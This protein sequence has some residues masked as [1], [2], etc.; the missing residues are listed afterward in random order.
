MTRVRCYAGYF[1]ARSGKN[2]AFGILVNN[3]RGGS[4][5]IINNIEAI[6]KDFILYK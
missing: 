1:S 4:P 6:L 2:Y 3:F 5:Y